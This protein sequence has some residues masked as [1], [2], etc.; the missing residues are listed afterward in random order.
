MAMPGRV[1]R[2][3]AR[4]LAAVPTL[5]T[6]RAEL[7]TEFYRGGGGGTV[8]V[9]VQRALAFRHLVERRTIWI[10]EDELIVG[11]KGPA[12]KA[13]PTYPELCCHSLE[14]FERLDTREKIP[15]RVDARAREIQARDVIPFWR[16]QSMR[17]L[18]FDAM[19]DDW[20][21]AYAAGVFTEFM[22]QRAPGRGR[23]LRRCALTRLC[24]L[25]RPRHSPA[26][27]P[28]PRDARRSGS[29]RPTRCA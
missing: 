20:R 14:D 16:G 27:A 5:S 13:A 7:I 2:L 25:G 4:S 17:D 6:E 29:P 8:S 21:E 12:P 15:F 11:E 9:P 28:S 22:E 24:A 1:E 19:T 10:G 23:K 18:I 26:P 3:R